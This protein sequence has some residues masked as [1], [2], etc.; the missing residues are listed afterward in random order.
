MERPTPMRDHLVP[1]PSQ[2]LA[3]YN[4]H[5]KSSSYCLSTPFPC[6]ALHPGKLTS[7]GGMSGFL[8]S[9]FQAGLFSGRLEV[10]RGRFWGINSVP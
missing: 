4:T 7:T 10:R 8:H 2:K 5:P 1:T 9:E 6:P 3:P